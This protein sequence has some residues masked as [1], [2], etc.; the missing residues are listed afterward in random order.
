MGYNGSTLTKQVKTMAM[1][2]ATEEKI[3]S[4]VMYSM[5]FLMG[6]IIALFLFGATQT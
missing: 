4:G 1:K 2:E 3:L 6:I 5:I